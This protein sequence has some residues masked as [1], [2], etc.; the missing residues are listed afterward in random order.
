MCGPGISVCMKK[1][2]KRVRG[3]SGGISS[4][5]ENKQQKYKKPLTF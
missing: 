1:C 4:R 5:Q 3:Q 2:E